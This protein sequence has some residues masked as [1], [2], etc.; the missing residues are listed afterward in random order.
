MSTTLITLKTNKAV[1]RQAQEL[2][3]KMGF[4]LSGVINWFL[5][6]F[7]QTK[8]INFTYSQWDN[9]SSNWFSDDAE[10]KLLQ[11]SKDAKKNWP[12]FNS[13]EELFDDLNQ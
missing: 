13:L 4:S 10:D 7:I 2:A 1:K 5:H 12:R 9:I 8:N 6:Q 11:E 3:K